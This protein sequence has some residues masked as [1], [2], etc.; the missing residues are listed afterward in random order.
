MPTPGRWMALLGRGS[1]CRWR[2][3]EAG[4]RNSEEL[5]SLEGGPKLSSSS[6]LLLPHN[7]SLKCPE[8]KHGCAAHHPPWGPHSTA[9]HPSAIIRAEGHLPAATRKMGMRFLGQSRSK[10]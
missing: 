1:K 8:K 2:G 4:Q 9:K 5:D 6:P 7:Y 3:W 10:G